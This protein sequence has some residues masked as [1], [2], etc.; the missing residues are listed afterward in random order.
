MRDEESFD[1]EQQQQPHI[2]Y[3]EY[4][5][6]VKKNPNESVIMF[7]SAFFVMLLLFL[8]IAK[9]LSPD[10][11]VSI[12]SNEQTTSDDTADYEDYAKSSIDERLKL[13]QLE[14]AGVHSDNENIF[15]D[16]LEERVE[17]P[18][19]VKKHA[20]ADEESTATTDP[21]DPLPSE[22]MQKEAVSQNIVEHP[23]TKPESPQ[24][25]AAP[26]ET[27]SQQA[28][29]APTPVNAKVVVGYYSTAEQAQV[30]KGILMDAGLNIN[31]FVKQIG[32]A[33]TIQVGSFSTREKAQSVANDL[34]RNNFP[35]RI[36]VEP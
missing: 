24:P 2:N 7:I 11:D 27:T 36:I 33:Y 3:K 12:G 15:D 4:S 17:L 29:T 14:D 32:G 9:Q 35:A 22:Q 31:P 25:T 1:L 30:A 16:S 34:L 13:I 19:S 23:V 21:N 20:K 10:V 28:A 26:Q 8:G 5:N 18:D 6:K